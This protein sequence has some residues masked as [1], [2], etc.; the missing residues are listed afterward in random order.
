MEGGCGYRTAD[1]GCSSGFGFGRKTHHKKQ[2]VTKVTYDLEL[3]GF[4]GTTLYLWSR[5]RKMAVRLDLNPKSRLE[6]N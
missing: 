5:R 3:N 1:K 4:F 2:H 6:R